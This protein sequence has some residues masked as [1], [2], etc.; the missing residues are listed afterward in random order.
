[1]RI[2]RVRVYGK[3]EGFMAW[4]R[5]MWEEVGKEWIHQMEHRG[6]VENVCGG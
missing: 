5:C 3:R 2:G 1:M 6:G 4:G